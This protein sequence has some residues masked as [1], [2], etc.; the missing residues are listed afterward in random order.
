M[1]DKI[2]NIYFQADWIMCNKD[3]RGFQ[4]WPHCPAGAD[5]LSG[6]ARHGILNTA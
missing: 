4:M 3:L 1:Y 2:V 6:Q 5:K